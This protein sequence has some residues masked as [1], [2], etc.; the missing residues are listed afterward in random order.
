MTLPLTI[1]PGEIQ[2]VACPDSTKYYKWAGAATTAQYYINKQDVPES[3]ACRWG[4]EGT[5][6][7]NWAPVNF[8]VGYNGQLGYM[9]LFPNEPTSPGSK[10]DFTVEFVSDSMDGKCK[11]TDG[12]YYG[13]GDAGKGCTVSCP[14][15]IWCL[16]THNAGR[17]PSGW[18]SDC[19]TL[20]V[21]G[22]PHLLTRRRPYHLSC[23]SYL[24][25]YHSFIFGFHQTMV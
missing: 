2:E 25:M 12:T 15:F 13:G 9:A 10:L 17:P 21:S 19:G 3:Q 14:T 16:P 4:Q 8:G 23:F 20:L 18:S 1:Q 24:D 7:G 11:Y 22:T 5:E 6:R